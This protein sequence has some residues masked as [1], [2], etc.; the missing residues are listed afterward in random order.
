[1]RQPTELQAAKERVTAILQDPKFK[2]YVDELRNLRE[3]Y[4]HAM[5]LAKTPEDSHKLA[6]VIHGL[7]IALEL[8]THIGK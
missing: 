5:Y 7:T 4:I 8:N 6:G 3:Q 2:S 1:M